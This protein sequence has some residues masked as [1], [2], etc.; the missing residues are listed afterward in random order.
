[1]KDG[2]ASS[3]NRQHR[4]T[5]L[6]FLI[7]VPA[8]S[9]DSYQQGL[10]KTYKK[11]LEEK[12]YKM[13]RDLVIQFIKEKMDTNYKKYLQAK[14]IIKYSNKKGKSVGIA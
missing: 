5:F 2:E 9:L 8:A 7:F 11:K 1:M 14:R 13:R 12:T 10:S 4:I 6:V 3:Q